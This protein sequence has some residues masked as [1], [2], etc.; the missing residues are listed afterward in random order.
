MDTCISM[1]KCRVDKTLEEKKKRCPNFKRVKEDQWKINR[2]NLQH[3]TKKS[4]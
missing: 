1:Q 4:F 3:Y 2:L